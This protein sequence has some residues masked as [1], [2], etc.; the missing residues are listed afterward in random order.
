MNCAFCHQLRQEFLCAPCTSRKIQTKTVLLKQQET[1]IDSLEGKLQHELR[2][3]TKIENENLQWIQRKR[4][5]QFLQYQTEQILL[6]IHA[7]LRS[8][9]S[10]S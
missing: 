8:L 4:E 6:Q 2:P 1:Q 5:T 9:P 3:L 10:P 7:L